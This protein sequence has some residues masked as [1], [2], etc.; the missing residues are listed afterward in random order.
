MLNQLLNPQQG[1]PFAARAVLRTQ[2]GL[3]TETN[4]PP[5]AT[6][7]TSAPTNVSSMNAPATN[8]VGK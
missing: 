1:L 5:A 6:I 2:L 3:P 7:L 4:A 8:S